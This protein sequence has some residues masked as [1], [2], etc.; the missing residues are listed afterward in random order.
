[1]IAVSLSLES[2]QLAGNQQNIISAKDKT[3]PKRIQQEVFH[4]KSQQVFWNSTWK[5]YIL[6]NI[7]LTEWK[8]FSAMM[9]YEN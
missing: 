2:L 6:E 1:M 9:N 8:M 4:L 7:K 5:H 3:K